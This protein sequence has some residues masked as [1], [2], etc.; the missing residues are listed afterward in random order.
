MEPRIEPVRVTQPGQVTPG[1]DER[2]LD[3]IARQL[4]VP[5]DQP[6][7]RVQ[8]RDGDSTSTAKAS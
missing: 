3:R 6:G 1:S 2:F 5:E 8:A 7:G 4:A